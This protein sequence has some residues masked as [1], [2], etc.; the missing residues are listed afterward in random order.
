MMHRPRTPAAEPPNSAGDRHAASSNRGVGQVISGEPDRELVR[1]ERRR[2]LNPT[3]QV[4]GSTYLSPTSM[5]TA[6]AA[7]PAAHP[8]NRP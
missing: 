6:I 3:R 8:V 5:T 2:P 7:S 4:H 1:R